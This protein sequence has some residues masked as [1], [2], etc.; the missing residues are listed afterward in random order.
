MNVLLL[1]ETGPIPKYLALWILMAVATVLIMYPC[2]FSCLWVKGI[3]ITAIMLS[4]THN[5]NLHLDCQWFENFMSTNLKTTIRTHH[6]QILFGIRSENWIIYKM[7]QKYMMMS[8]N[9]NIFCITVP[10]WGESTNHWWIPLTK[11]SD[12]ELWLFLWSAPEKMVEQTIKTPVIW[13]AITLI[14]MSL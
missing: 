14:M 5:Y 13:D 2:V 4:R 1:Y 9:E 11:A 6:F 12:T 7:M 10:L 3:A 8:S